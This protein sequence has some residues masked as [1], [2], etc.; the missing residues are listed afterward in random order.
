MT[1]TMIALFLL[2][3]TIM[4]YFIINWLNFILFLCIGP[5][6]IIKLNFIW[7]SIPIIYPPYKDF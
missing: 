5:H 4:D 1:I 2:I 7:D 3:T 6:L